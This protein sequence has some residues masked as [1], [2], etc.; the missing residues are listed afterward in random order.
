MVIRTAEAKMV[1]YTSLHT[2]ASGV[3]S[4]KNIKYPLEDFRLFGNSKSK[5][6]SLLSV[7][8]IVSRRREKWRSEF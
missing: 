7:F 8:C 4:D 1:A 3:L 2:F 6:M 5:N